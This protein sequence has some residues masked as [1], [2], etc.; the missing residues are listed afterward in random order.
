MVW[1]L[2][3]VVV[4]GGGVVVVVKGGWFVALVAVRGSIAR[5]SPVIPPVPVAPQ[6]TRHAP[7]LTCKGGGAGEGGGAVTIQGMFVLDN[8]M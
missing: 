1:V 2:R 3:V 4:V 8:Q 6:H 7:A 5:T